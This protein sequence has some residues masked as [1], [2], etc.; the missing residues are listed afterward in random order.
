MAKKIRRAKV[1]KAKT[2]ATGKRKAKVA[3]RAGA[4]TKGGFTINFGPKKVKLI[5]AAAEKAN[6]KG[7]PRAFLTKHLENIVS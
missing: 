4:S 6:F 2:G 3:G 5:A 7:T 1:A